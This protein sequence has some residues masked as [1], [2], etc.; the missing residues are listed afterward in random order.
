MLGH[1]LGPGPRLW[2]NIVVSSDDDGTVRDNTGSTN[3]ESEAFEEGYKEETEASLE[4]LC[5]KVGT[6]LGF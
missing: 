1:E 5:R 6:V 4:S 3:T 2:I